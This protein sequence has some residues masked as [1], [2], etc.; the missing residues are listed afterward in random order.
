MAFDGLVLYTLVQEATDKLINARVDKI[1]Q[2]DPDLLTITMRGHGEN[3]QLLFSANPQYARVHFTDE[4]FINPPHPPAFCMLMR[5]YLG[6]GRV[7]EV[8][9][10]G[11]ERIFEL[12]IQNINE[13]GELT[14]YRLIM[15][16]M[17]RHSNL[18]LV[19]ERGDILDGMK[20][21]PEGISRHREVLPGRPYINPP[22]QDKAN[23]LMAEEPAFKAL[24]Q[25]DPEA[26]LFQAVMNNYTGISPLIAKEIV[27]RAGLAPESKLR[28]ETPD[29][30]DRLWQAFN[31]VF[32]TL[33]IRQFTPTLVE[34]TEGNVVAYSCITLQQFAGMQQRTFGEMSQLL[35]YY[36]SKK[37]KNQALGQISGDLKKAISTL[38]DKDLKKHDKLTNQMAEAQNAEEYRIK[39]EMLK[40]NI[41]LVEKGV[42]SIK[43]VNYYDPEMQELTIELDPAISPQ[44]NAQKYFKRYN[45]LKNS[46]RYIE[47]ELAKLDL[48]IEYL[49]N[50]ELSLQQIES[51]LDLEEIREELMEEGYL[52]DT[53][54]ATPN[55]NKARSKPMK[56][57]S[58]D[59]FDILVGRNNR[60]NDELSKK[61][62]ARDD[63]WFHTKEIPGSHVIIRNFDRRP[64]PEQTIQEAATLSAYFSKARES[65]NV[66]VDYTQIK[67]V[68]KPKGAKPGMVIY[69]NY[70][71]LVVNPDDKL[72]ESLRA[73]A[74]EESQGS[75][76]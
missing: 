39:G 73:R 65:A 62:A 38:L 11:F 57:K 25:L 52:K 17:G 71:T 47:Q 40:A 55:R 70:Q 27:V 24:L 32:Q 9:Q 51:K 60:Q 2:P 16:L 75:P 33:Q 64:I 54:K 15:E 66:Q 41:H 19:D 26:K 14:T 44:A 68:S 72:V 4:K 12:V 37:I 59:G 6:G 53:R 18:I 48:E 23:P 42:P 29:A 69:V 20:R 76:I 50:V 67:N 10:P 61:L 34:D 43:V 22:E 74:Q 63:L 13:E 7:L 46:I 30:L 45:K 28:E 49:W 8:R 31:A 21:I 58:S 56:F 36:F 3:V 35:N 5:K 1:Y